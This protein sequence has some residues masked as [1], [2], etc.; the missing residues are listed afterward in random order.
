MITIAKN[1]LYR[2]FLSPMAWVILALTQLLLAYLFLTHIDYF[3]QIQAQLA[4]IDGAPGVTE[5]VITPL[6][7]NAGIILL[8]ITPFITMRLF[9]EERRNDNLSL[10]LSAPISIRSLVLGKFL[11]ATFFFMVLLLLLAAMAFSL[12]VGARLDMGLFAAGLLGLIL[13][14]SAMTAIGLYLSS[15][16]KYP[17]IAA[18]TSFAGLFLFWIID[19]AGKHNADSTLFSWLSLSHH[20]QALIQGEIHSKDIAY[21]LILIATFLILTIRQLDSQR[22][23]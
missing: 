2:L 3:S 1:E 18:M 23:H 13:L 22:L 20:F 11:G 21:Y 7:N 4:T 16:T 9:A 19:W 17:A 5:M 15:L 8:F 14:I 6:F 12:Q 10:L